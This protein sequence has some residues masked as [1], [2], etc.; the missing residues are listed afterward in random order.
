MEAETPGSRKEFFKTRKGRASDRVLST[1]FGARRFGVVRV[2]GEGQRRP[3]KRSPAMAVT[4]LKAL[5]PSLLRC[6]SEA[7]QID[8][9]ALRLVTRAFVLQAPL[10]AGSHLRG[11]LGGCLAGLT[12]FFGISGLAQRVPTASAQSPSAVPPVSEKRE[13]FRH[14]FGPDSPWN[15]K[16]PSGAAYQ[17]IEGIGKYS[18]DINYEGRFTTG[19]FRATANDRMAVLY[20]HDYTLWELLHSGKVKT[21]GNSPEVEDSL[22]KA[23][24]R[25]AMFPANYYSTIIRSPPG[26]R[27]WPS[28]VNP[29]A[30]HWTNK[31]YVPS[32]AAASP[33]DDGQLAVMQP[34]GWM[35]EC[36]AAVVC[37]NGDVVSSMASFTDPASDGT[38]TN[39]GRCASL[40]N[41]YAGLIRKGELQEGMIPH[42]LSCHVSR[43]LLH[44]S[45]VWPASAFD[46]NDNYQG[47]LPMGS[48]L[49]IPP[50][51]RLDTLGLS[52]KGLVI[53]QAAQRYGIYVVDRSGDGSIIIKAATDA[54]DARYA[55]SGRDMSILIKL[56]QRVTSNGAGANRAEPAH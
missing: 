52:A 50:Q 29:V 51:I 20:I 41:N 17:T 5:G 39:N 56:L 18:G 35:L 27:T 28:Q 6:R 24:S 19:I 32:D 13:F 12:L 4:T 44:P 1:R 16:I 26:K 42:A 37:A 23:S 45:V 36:Y 40:L 54:D 2:W 21:I 9:M 3:G 55:D 8:G 46:M 47:T 49:A 33:D 48:L 31:I 43:L 22:R 53:A 34:N 15:T 30:S 25:Q 14:P 10:K 7:W 11:F 38:G